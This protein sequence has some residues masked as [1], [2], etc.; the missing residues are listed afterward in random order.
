LRA[1]DPPGLRS[2]LFSPL[3]QHEPSCSL[4]SFAAGRLEFLAA[5]RVVGNE[6]MLNLID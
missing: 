4:W 5:D 1:L 6:E 2:D 3:L